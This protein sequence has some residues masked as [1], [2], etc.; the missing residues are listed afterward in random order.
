MYCI[1]HHIYKKTSLTI[2]FELKTLRMTILVSTCMVNKP[3]AVVPFV[4]TYDIDLCE[5]TFGAI[6]RLLV[7]QM[8]SHFDR[9][10]FE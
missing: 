9:R 2:T 7:G 5:I 10:Y 6:S 3:Y 1:G 4:L 8:L